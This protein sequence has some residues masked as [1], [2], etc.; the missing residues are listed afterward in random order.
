MYNMTTAAVKWPSISMGVFSMANFRGAVLLCNEC[1][2]EFRVPPSRAKSARYCSKKC[3]DLNRSDMMPK[4]R[5]SKRC[6]NCGDTF[7]V[8]ESHAGRRKYC[9]SRCKHTGSA[10]R[11]ELAMRTTGEQ[12]GNWKGGVVIKTDKYLYESAPHHP[13]ASNG[14]VLQH[15]LVMERH[16]RETDPA[17]PFLVKIGDNLYLSPDFIVHHK[18]ENRQNND[19]DNLQCMTPGDHVRHHQEHKGNI[20]KCGACGKDFHVPDSRKE[21]A[22][23][24]SRVCADSAK[25]H[26]H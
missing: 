21:T 5:V 17:S 1:G 10:Y 4:K 8:P 25:R 12:N 23:Y 2:Q 9:S 20:V 22:K 24:C 16:L 7:E 18:D 11:S 26:F 6:P 3:A 15:R 19:I 13:L 14:Y